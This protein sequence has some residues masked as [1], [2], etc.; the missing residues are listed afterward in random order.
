MAD[1]IK[2]T[3][4]LDSLEWLILARNEAMS[5]WKKV[6]HR[7]VQPLW[8]FHLDTDDAT[9]IGNFKTTMDSAREDG[10]NMYIPKGAVVPEL[11]S[12][13]TNSSLNPLAW[14]QQLN[15]YFFQ[16]VMTP[17]IIVGNS[18]EFT[19][20][21]AKIGYLAFEQN[22]KA[23]QLYAEEQVLGQLNLEIFLT[24]PATLQQDLVSGMAQDPKL[25]A[26]QPNDTTAEMEGRA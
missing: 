8:I 20:A 7:N 21:S 3:R 17:Q 1:E 14:I 19:D 26:S 2:G 25:L 23:K 5:D 15:S 24:F 11:V 16:A 13:A 18:Q 10:E 12:T 6:L 4:I 22:I 9:E